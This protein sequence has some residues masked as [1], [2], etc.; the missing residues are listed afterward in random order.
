MYFSFERTLVSP[1]LMTVH[2]EEI[3]LVFLKYSIVRGVALVT[4]WMLRLIVLP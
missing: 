4:I 3:L 2:K 1:Y